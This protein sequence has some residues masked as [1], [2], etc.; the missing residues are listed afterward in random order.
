[1]RIELRQR[2]VGWMSS[3]ELDQVGNSDSPGRVAHSLDIESTARVVGCVFYGSK[4][5]SVLVS[6]DAEGY[7]WV[8][9]AAMASW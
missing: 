3:L 6:A 4:D 1:M 8:R 9:G 2:V 7:I 5:I